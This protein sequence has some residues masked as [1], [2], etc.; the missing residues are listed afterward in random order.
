MHQQSMSGYF[1]LHTEAAARESVTRRLALPVIVILHV[2]MVYF[3]FGAKHR[4][5]TEGLAAA[6]LVVRFL[7]AA[8]QAATAPAEQA[9]RPLP[10]AHPLAPQAITVPP[11]PFPAPA[12]AQPAVPAPSPDTANPGNSITDITS[13]AMLSIGKIDRELRKEFPRLEES[14][15]DSTQARLAKGIAAAGVA[16][17]TTMQEKVFPDGRRVTKVSGP[18]Y[19]YCVTTDSVGHD[20]GFDQMQRG[21]KSKTTNCGNLFD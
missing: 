18:G 15:P 14:R 19:S 10:L 2:L 17:G 6:P 11:L 13:S 8:A 3:W 4:A 12:P 16:Q 1:P 21:V 5:A 7:S 20:S 9:S